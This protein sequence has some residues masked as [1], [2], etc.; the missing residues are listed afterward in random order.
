MKNELDLF[1]LYL[2]RQHA[3]RPTWID[4]TIQVGRRASTQRFESADLNR[5]RFT[6]ADVNR[7]SDP[8]RPTR[9]DTAIQVGRREPASIQVGRR[10]STQR[11]KSGGPN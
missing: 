1:S 10:E 9:I 8:S 4:A 7:R 6:S 5:W 2:L 11:F 3:S